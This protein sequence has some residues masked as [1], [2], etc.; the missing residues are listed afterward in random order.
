MPNFC[1]NR[2]TIR[3]DII[4]REEFVNEVRG[5]PVSWTDT[6]P[7]DVKEKVIEETLSFHTIM[8]VPEN[9][10]C[11]NEGGYQWCSEHWGTKWCALD[12]KLLHDDR[13][14]GY[15][16]LTAWAPPSIQFLTILA[17]KFPDVSIDLRYAEKGCNFYG[18]WKSNGEAKSWTFDDDDIEGI[19]AERQLC[20]KLETYA[21]LWTMS[22]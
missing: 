4:K 6:F 8:P 18:Y 9:C 7:L 11:F 17:E 14:T 19:D 1:G 21:D 12:T 22:G 16:F 13:E 15:T 3:G 10:H 20:V 5:P 2:L